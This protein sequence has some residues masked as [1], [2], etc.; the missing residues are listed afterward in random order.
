MYSIEPSAPVHPLSS[1]VR[2]KNENRVKDIGPEIRLLPAPEFDVTIRVGCSLMYEATGPAWLL[3]N[4]KPRPD[5]NHAVVF[6]A[7]SLGNQLPAEEFVDSHGNHLY[8]RA[9]R[10]GA[11]MRSGT[12]RHCLGLFAAGQS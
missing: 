7:L 6:E 4:L 2:T 3:L 8:P 10:G 5:R 1:R 12:S 11:A 9:A